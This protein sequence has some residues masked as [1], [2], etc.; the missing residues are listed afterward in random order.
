MRKNVLYGVAS[1]ALCLC[2]FGCHSDTPPPV[3]PGG[4]QAA[5]ESKGQTATSGISASKPAGAQDPQ[6]GTKSNGH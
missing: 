5:A 1:V 3:A 4:P 2:M 6:F